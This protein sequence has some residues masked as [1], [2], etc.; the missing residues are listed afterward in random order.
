[1]KNFWKGIG[2]I[3][4]FLSVVTVAIVFIQEGLLPALLLT[5]FFIV[6]LSFMYKVLKIL[7]N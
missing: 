7:M 6:S 2:I 1:M 4:I 5:A 3:A